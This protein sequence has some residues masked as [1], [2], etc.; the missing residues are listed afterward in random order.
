MSPLRVLV[1]QAE[2]DVLADAIAQALSRAPEVALVSPFA[3]PIERLDDMLAD[4]VADIEVMIAIGNVLTGLTDKWLSKYPH[5]VLSHVAI[6]PDVV[7]I[8]VRNIGL[9][10]MLLALRALARSPARHPSRRRL[11]YRL[12][13][14]TT[15]A[16]H[17]GG[18]VIE[19]QRDGRPL[20]RAVIEWLDKQL[21]RHCGTSTTDSD[22]VRGLSRSAFSIQAQLMSQADANERVPRDARLD[23]STAL[24]LTAIDNAA[25]SGEPLGMLFSALGLTQLEMCALLIALAPELDQKYQ[26]VFGF[27]HDDLTRRAASLGLICAVLGEPSEIRHELGGS[28]GLLYWRLITS[29]NTLPCSEDMIR[30]DAPVV[31]WLLGNDSA[32]LEEAERSGLTRTTPWPGAGWMHHPD[33]TLSREKLA[34]RLTGARGQD[35]W[36]ALC[37]PDA[38]GWSALLESVAADAGLRLLR[39][40]L[41]ELTKLE[42]GQRR[43]SV[44]SLVRAALL[45]GC[46]PVVDA[47]DPNPTDVDLRALAELRDAL[48]RARRFGVIV[49]MDVGRFAGTLPLASNG[50]LYR[51]ASSP[52]R[53]GAALSTAAHEIGIDLPAADAERLARSTPPRFAVIHDAM[54]LAQANTTD[55][56]SGDAD[57][58]SISACLRNVSAPR[59]PRFARRVVPVV[60][61]DQVIL[62]EDRRAQ[63]D[64]L[65]AHVEHA[66]LVLGEWGFESGRTPSRGIA[67]L[68]CG[69]SGTGKSMAAEAVAHALH[70]DA[71]LVD[72]AQV[73]SKYIGESE[74]N[75]DIVFSEAEQAGAVL[76]FNEA[77]VLFSK[78]GEVRDAHDRYANMEV[79]YLLQRME[80]FSGLAVLT[81]NFR[82]NVDQAF[83][84]RLRFVVEFPKPD[85]RA[86]EAIWQQC[87][88]A[89]APR[90]ADV[91]CRFLARRLEL[92][93]G[94]IAQI[95]LRAAFAAAQEQ[96]KEI[97][98]RHILAA[99]RAE[100]LKFGMVSVERDLA[101][102]EASC[103]A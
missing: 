25:T 57:T 4:G 16:S 49:S 77:D 1:V 47:T 63:L 68:F 42:P 100:L 91:D 69:A 48:E 17:F 50:V 9:H 74:K 90:A 8:K 24:L 83:L 11:E 22:E 7:H 58:T 39:I 89:S 44:T 13:A 18:E 76:V 27:L 12:V 30:V 36:V 98:L 43:D 75:L 81:T 41:G 70:T 72:L 102:F 26:T 79:A 101:A 28:C 55:G 40:S 21:L 53:L 61:L 20:H 60:G 38:D 66:S 3:V 65:V 71:W 62:P 92:T 6:S 93:G 67:A 35:T 37:G 87:L 82:Q 19:M 64:E 29:S 23:E 45:L 32:L 88:P 10:Q 94:S 86:R 103:A 54:R 80:Q 51:P 97:G 59:L 33:D 73:V 14:S 95:T 56:G 85:A 52:A 78:R 99:T 34:A 31:D 15:S 2:T 5:L 96:C 46:L 84:R